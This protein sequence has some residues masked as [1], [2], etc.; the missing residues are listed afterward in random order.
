M[1]I[2]KAKFW[3]PYNGEIV[4]SVNGGKLTVSTE[5]GKKITANA[6]A[7]QPKILEALR[8]LENTLD[9]VLGVD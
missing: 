3:G 6:F 5:R 2:E 1:L 4:L 9:K 8:N 7:N